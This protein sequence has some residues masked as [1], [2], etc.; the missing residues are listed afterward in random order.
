MTERHDHR[1]VGTL[2]AADLGKPCR[3]EWEG[4]THTGTLR[5]AEHALSMG[6]AHTFVI[7]NSESGASWM[8]HLPT[9]HPIAVRVE[10]TA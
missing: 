1:E 8:K 6:R 2:T 4:W 10:E 7:V 5:E 3:I 9:D